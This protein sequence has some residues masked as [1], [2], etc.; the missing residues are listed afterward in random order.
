MAV[1][2]EKPARR[3]DRKRVRVTSSG[4]SG[5][6]D[7]SALLCAAALQVPGRGVYLAATPD[8]HTDKFLQHER[9]VEA[10]F[11]VVRSPAQMPKYFH[12]LANMN[13]CVTWLMRTPRARV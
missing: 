6:L 10:R 9:R 2:P 3:H 7:R 4:D 5:S 1:W 12:V 8:G 11:E 13:E